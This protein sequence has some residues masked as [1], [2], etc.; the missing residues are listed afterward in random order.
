MA[1]E[2]R[3]ETLVK[4]MDI[5]TEKMVL[6]GEEFEKIKTKHRRL[7]GKCFSLEKHLQRHR[8]LEGTQM[9]SVAKELMIQVLNAARGVIN[10]ED[11]I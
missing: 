3:M 11:D 9:E 5:L 7:E 1:N 6:M 2:K 4:H 10:R 8:L